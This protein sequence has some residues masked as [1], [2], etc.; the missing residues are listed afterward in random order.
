[1]SAPIRLCLLDL[2]LVACPSCEGEG[3]IEYGNGNDPTDR[4]VVC[5]E[6]EGDGRVEIVAD[7]LDE[8]DCWEG[9]DERQG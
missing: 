1:M 2:R 3:R 5:E 7:P 9:L 6:C 8:T 4:S